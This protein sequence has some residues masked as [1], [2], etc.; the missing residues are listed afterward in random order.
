MMQTDAGGGNERRAIGS[1]T[2]VIT[3]I[4]VLIAGGLA[5]IGLLQASGIALLAALAASVATATQRP[6]RIVSWIPPMVIVVAIVT[7]ALAD[8]IGIGTH[9]AGA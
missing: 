4:L 2:V 6:R 9:H 3:T 5:S 1:A 7:V 8:V